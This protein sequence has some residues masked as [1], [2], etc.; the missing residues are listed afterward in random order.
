MPVPIDYAALVRPQVAKLKPYTPGTTVSQA[1]AKYGLEHFVKLSSNENPLGTSPRA[2]AALQSLGELQIYVD[3]DHH[4]LR[5]RLAAPH[6]LQ[7][8]N[9]LVGHGSNDVVRTLF[10]ALLVPG[11]EVVVADPTFSLFPKDAMLFDATAVKVPLR[12]GVHDLDAMLA[13]VTPKTKLVVVV[14]PN[15]PT[16]TAVD[17]GAFERFARALPERVVLMIDQAYREYMP[18]GSVEGAAYAAS[19]PATIVLRTMSKIYGFASLRFGYAL[20]DA[21]LLAYVERVR[22][23]FGVSRPAAVA[24]LAALDDDDFL[25][26]SVANNEAGKAL[27][28][29]AF[30]RL[31]LHAYTTAANFVA[32]E[33][34][35]T[36]TEAYETLLARGIVTRSGDALGMPGRLR[37]TIGT[38]EENALL[39]DALRSLAPAAA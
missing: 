13:A 11:D 37:I 34:R 1:K 10:T 16:A 6:G 17:R 31:G 23:P 29:P 25:R 36:A 39:L 8:A 26:R 30:E 19:R 18:A 33:V 7:A 3:D 27:L 15:N 20:G 4:E 21:A 22:V 28:Y 9:V 35:G 32:L 38:P 24:A 2:L 5:E 12:D 14:D